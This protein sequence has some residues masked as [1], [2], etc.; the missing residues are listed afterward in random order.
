MWAAL[1]ICAVMAVGAR[2]SGPAEEDPAR[3]GSGR[4]SA[5]VL[6]RARDGGYLAAWESVEA[7]GRHD[8]LFSRRSPGERGEWS[9]PPVRLDTDAPGAARSLEPRLA[10]GTAGLVVAAWQDARSGC[11][12]VHVN[13]STDGGRTWLARDV[14]VESDLPGAA[15]S[16]MISLASDGALGFY[17]AWED[18]RSGD[19]DIYFTRSLD[20]GATWETDRRVDSDDRGGASFHPQIACWP[21]GALAVVWWDERDGLGDV[22][23]RRSTDAGASWDG[24]ETR[25]DEGEVG[26]CASHDVRLAVE[27]DS[28]F[29][30]WREGLGEVTVDV[31]RV[32][33]DRG[34][35]FAPPSRPARAML[36]AGAVREADG[37]V[38]TLD[39]R[40]GGDGL[41]FV[42][43]AVSRPSGTER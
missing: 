1:G 18:Q 21:D 14:R 27:E 28:L 24:A 4:P 6:L 19:R 30:R 39:V 7:G 12:D 9:A 33:A 2:P 8:V 36:P 41:R 11:D 26:A 29:V 31:E 22:Y 38:A 37:G 16:S 10:R 20:G 40:P 34:G 15:A 13:R 35:T 3:G 25:L 42:R 17:L 43:G 5:P 32:S 23:V